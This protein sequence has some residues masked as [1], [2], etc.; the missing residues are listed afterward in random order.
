MTTASGY[1]WDP[2]TRPAPFDASKFPRTGVIGEIKPH[3]RAGISAGIA[4]LRGRKGI[5]QRTPQLVTYRQVPGQPTRYEILAADSTQLAGVIRGRRAKID[6]W[7][8]LG[9]IES[10]RATMA[11][12]LWQCSTSLGNLLERQIRQRYQ[13]RVGTTL[14]AKGSASQTGADITHE[15]QEMAEFLRELATELEAEAGYPRF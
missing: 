4:Q 9:I 7:Y 13:A 1:R 11:I 2:A 6:T 10:S 5:T 12:P 14:D 8:T 3:N 15:R